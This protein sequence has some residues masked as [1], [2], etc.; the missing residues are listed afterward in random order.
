MKA[1]VLYKI[2]GTEKMG[3]GQPGTSGPGAVV[4][5]ASRRNTAQA[6]S[7]MPLPA[8]SLTVRDVFPDEMVVF[9]FDGLDQKVRQDLS[10]CLSAQ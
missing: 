9:S 10:S 1:T 6:S 4:L 8:H 5:G 3:N 2:S 7:A